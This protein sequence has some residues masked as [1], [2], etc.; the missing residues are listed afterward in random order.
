MD[1]EK[2]NC[3][4]RRFPELRA[5]AIDS[6]A[7]RPSHLRNLRFAALAIRA[8]THLAS[9]EKQETRYRG[10]CTKGRPV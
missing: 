8:E 10:Q 2:A 1:G 5:R 7:S 9:G 3:R 4:F 6:P